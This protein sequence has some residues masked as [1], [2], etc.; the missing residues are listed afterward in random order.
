M[1]ESF[2]NL[3]I[4]KDSLNL[5]REIYLVTKTFP[6]DEQFGL[7]SQLRRASVSISANISEG[8]GR[9]TKTDFARFVSI[10]KGSLYEVESLLYVSEKI[11]YISKS[12]LEMLLKIT[13]SLGVSIGAF[14]NH[15]K[16]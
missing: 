9:G 13:D 1:A 10:A 2:A 15:L 3:N 14:V 12:D 6:K 5:A 16:K 8:S 11:G 7:I 4:W